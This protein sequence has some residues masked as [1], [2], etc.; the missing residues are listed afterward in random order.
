[1]VTYLNTIQIFGSLSCEQNTRLHLWESQDQRTQEQASLWS[2]LCWKGGSSLLGEVPFIALVAKAL[3][4]SSK[5]CCW[6]E[7]SPVLQVFVFFPMLTCTPV[8]LSSVA[9]PFEYYW[10]LGFT[11]PW[12]YERPISSHLISVPA[13]ASAHSV[14]CISPSFSF[15]RVHGCVFFNPFTTFVLCSCLDLSDV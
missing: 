12:L 14:L 5:A 2:S 1:M 8:F 3:H 10:R 6:G 15:S 9:Q 7:P 11:S 4:T 13:A